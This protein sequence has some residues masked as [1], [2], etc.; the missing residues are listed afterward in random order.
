MA[1]SPGITRTCS[2]GQ[3]HGVRLR[4]HEGVLSGRSAPLQWVH[5]GYM[6]GGTAW[7]EAVQKA[8]QASALPEQTGLVGTRRDRMGS[9][10]IELSALAVWRSGVR[11]PSGPPYSGSNPSVDPTQAPATGYMLVTCRRA[12]GPDCPL[13]SA[14][15]NLG[16]GHTGGHTLRAPHRNYGGITLASMRWSPTIAA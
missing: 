5:L 16:D 7:D 12:G 14:V 2:A 8:T 6:L 9:D 15:R 1:A 13:Q 4:S 3:L 10:R 11:A